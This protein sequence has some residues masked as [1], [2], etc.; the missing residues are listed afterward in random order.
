[1]KKTAAINGTIGDSVT[2]LQFSSIKCGINYQVIALATFVETHCNTFIF[3]NQGQTIA[4][5]DG[6]FT[7]APGES[8]SAPGEV[9]EMYTHKFNVSFQG[10]GTNLLVMVR[11][12][13]E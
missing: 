6:A 8:F 10:S 2:N 13:Y 3:I 5:I 12:Y 1:M 7:I 4:V 11:K 9:L